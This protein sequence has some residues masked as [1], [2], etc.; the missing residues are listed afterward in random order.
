MRRWCI[1]G[2][3]ALGVCSLDWFLHIMLYDVIED[4]TT[5]WI[6]LGLFFWGLLTRLVFAH[7]VIEDDTTSWIIFGLF[8]KTKPASCL[9]LFNGRFEYFGKIYFNTL[10]M[11]H[12]IINFDNGHTYTHTDIL[13]H[14]TH[15]YALIHTY[16]HTIIQYTCYIYIYT[17]Y[18]YYIYIKCE[19]GCAGNW[20]RCI[21]LFMYLF[22]CP[23]FS[24]NGSDWCFPPLDQDSICH[25]LL[26]LHQQGSSLYLHLFII[27][28]CWKCIC[29]IHNLS[30]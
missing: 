13:I 25:D 17:V 20:K 9:V 8:F 19:K 5:S 16:I 12:F 29:D 3:I 27:H 30:N 14:H 23:C 11:C 15:T 2:E 26:P 18:I 10:C 4:D 7:Y 1:L 24:S 21:S 28:D 6:I 22:H